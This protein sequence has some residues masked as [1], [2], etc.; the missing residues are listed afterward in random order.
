MKINCIEYIRINKIQY[1]YSIENSY[2]NL[3]PDN[4]KCLDRRGDCG[5]INPHKQEH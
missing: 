1:K 3:L 2:Q 5:A 4:Y